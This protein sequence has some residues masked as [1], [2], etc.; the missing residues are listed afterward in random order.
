MSNKCESLQGASAGEESLRTTSLVLMLLNLAINVLVI[1]S[2]T[3]TS[4]LSPI[5]EDFETDLPLST[6]VMISPWTIAALIGIAV[7]S[8]AKEFLLKSDRRALILNALQLPLLLVFW[9]LQL[10]A[11]ILPLIES[12]T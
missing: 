7:A 8:V 6:Q 9:Q 3:R 12:L 4:V 11:R 5:L 10:E 2:L 1:I